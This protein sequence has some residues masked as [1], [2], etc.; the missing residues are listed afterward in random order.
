MPIATTAG[1]LLTIIVLS[2]LVAA[3]LAVAAA[4]AGLATAIAIWPAT[5][6][7]ALAT[8]LPEIVAGGERL[9][10]LTWIGSLGIDLAFRADGLS[11]LFALLI[12]GIGSCIFLYASRYLAGDPDQPRFFAFLSLFTG[13]M[14]G[15]CWLMT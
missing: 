6:F 4:R 7:A 15:A 3:P 9:E 14:L 10:Q 11:L 5:M 8:L 13:A 12:T 1:M 2:S